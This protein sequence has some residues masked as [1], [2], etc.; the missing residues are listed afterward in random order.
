MPIWIIKYWI[1]IPAVLITAFVAFQLHKIDTA[2][3][4]A[5][6]QAAL[7]AQEKQLNEA[8]DKAQ[9]INKEVS[10]DYQEQLSNLGRKLDTLKRVHANT[11]C[12]PITGTAA[13]RDGAAKPDK[14][15]GPNGIRAEWLYDT[16]AEADKYRLQ[17]IAC[18]D[19]IKKERE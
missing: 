9:Q 16:A 1:V 14:L 13:G 7:S 17:L 18:Q 2:R 3:L 12:V 19:F 11:Q 10:H 8:C 15:S 5:K 6:Y 4:E